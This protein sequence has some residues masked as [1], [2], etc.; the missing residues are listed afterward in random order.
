[1]TTQNHEKYYTDL[2]RDLQQLAAIDWPAFVELIGEDS[3][4]AAKVCVLKSRG[5]SQHQIANR[6]NITRSKAQ[7]NCQTCT[8][9]QK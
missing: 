1:M 3:L 7:R 9:L 5:K 2:D 8:S 4:I 6:L